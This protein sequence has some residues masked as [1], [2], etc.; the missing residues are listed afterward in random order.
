MKVAPN[1][2]ITNIRVNPAG[3]SIEALEINGEAVELGSAKLENN[4]AATIDVSTYTEPVEVTPT[5]GKT[6]MKKVTVTLDNIPS[7]ADLEANKAATIDVSTYTDPVEITPSEGKNGMEKVTVTL[8]N[9]P[10]GGGYNFYYWYNEDADSNYYTLTETPTTDNK[11]YVSGYRLARSSPTESISAT[12][13]NTITV[14]GV[15][16]TRDSSGDF[17]LTV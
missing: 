17:S 16:Y 3:E 7:G 10:S 15:V 5:S 6:G 2:R 4:K 12:G 1:Y 13:E 9:I 11:A 8:S 14:D